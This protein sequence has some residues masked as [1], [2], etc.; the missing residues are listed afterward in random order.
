MPL[1]D[2]LA[3]SFGALHA[4]DGVSLEVRNGEVFGLLGPNG[5]GKTTTL[6]LITGVLPADRGGVEF[7]ERPTDSRRQ[8][9]LCPH[10]TPV[11]VE[12]SGAENLRSFGAIHGLRGSHPAERVAWALEFSGLTDRV[13]CAS[14]AVKE[15]TG[16]T[17]Q[18]L[19][20]AP[21]S[22]AHRLAGKG[23]ACLL[24][25]VAL[26]AGLTV[27]S[28]LFLRV[29][30]FDQPVQLALAIASVGLCH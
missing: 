27:L 16:G 17:L 13:A 23:L 8:V 3:K 18:R 20:L 14:F 12:L 22:R 19:A 26:V 25:C 2:R 15:R 10:T 24:T 28:A 7:R 5:A 29:R 9:G 21:I 4:V 1:V 6:N 11:Y 30:A